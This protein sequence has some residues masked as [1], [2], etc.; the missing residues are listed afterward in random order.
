[1]WL[2]VCGYPQLSGSIKRAKD[3]KL[4]PQDQQSTS[5]PTSFLIWPLNLTHCQLYAQ[6]QCWQAPQ[7]LT[8][9]LLGSRCLL[10][11]L[12]LSQVTTLLGAFSFWSHIIRD[13]FVVKN[14]RWFGPVE[15]NIFVFLKG[16]TKTQYEFN[17]YIKMLIVA[18]FTGILALAGTLYAL[19]L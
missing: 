1:M 2:W 6:V 14:Y 3:I 10:C 8:H 7:I 12:N 16:I 18:M 11:A 4:L 9:C 15:L 5:A 19:Y 17:N 13:A